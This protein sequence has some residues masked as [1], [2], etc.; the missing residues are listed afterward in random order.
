M[1][2]VLDRRGASTGDVLIFL[3]T[4]G[5][6]AA[7]LYPAWSAREFRSRVAATVNDVEALRSAARSTLDERGTWPG[8]ASHSRVGYTLQW[9]SWNV[10]DSMV[11]VP[12]V[13]SAPGDAPSAAAGPTQVPIVRE[14]GAI[15]VHSSEAAL[16]AE[17]E[18]H[19]TGEMSF[20][21]DTMW[22]LVLPERG[23]PPSAGP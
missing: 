5:L 6:A 1:R 10:V 13:T 17:M 20:V 8:P 14:V 23:N 11:V 12:D 2:P 22:M 16:L 21:L 15:A 4:L 3:A 9:T 7:L 19:F 18:E